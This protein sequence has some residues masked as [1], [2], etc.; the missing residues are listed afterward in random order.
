M[1]ALSFDFGLKYI[2]VASL[3]PSSRIASR[4]GV[5]HAKNGIPDSA[6]LDFFVETWQPTEFIVGMPLNM[7][8]SESVMSKR[9]RKFG[10]F[11]ERRFSLQVHFVDERLTSVES[12]EQSGNGYP[13]HALAAVAIAN[14]WLHEEIV[15]KRR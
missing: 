1:S 13:D 5:L 10:K 3:E 12:R 6:Q 7:D 11:L 2:G 4:A 15:R 9:A 14:T 8:S